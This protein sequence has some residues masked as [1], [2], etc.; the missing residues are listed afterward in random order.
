MRLMVAEVNENCKAAA[1]LH[2]A[3]DGKWK[4]RER[5]SRDEAEL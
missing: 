5:V 1:E 2:P 3:F 4:A